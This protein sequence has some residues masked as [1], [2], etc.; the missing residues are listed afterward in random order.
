MTG[1]AS[2][3]GDGSA[4]VVSQ[5]KWE[6]GHLCCGAAGGAVGYIAHHWARGNTAA[7]EEGS[8]AC[9]NSSGVDGCR[10]GP[11]LSLKERA[12]RN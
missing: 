1:R 8:Q 11:K 12:V 2:F 4:R 9:A 6:T 5:V 10:E 3:A 7:L